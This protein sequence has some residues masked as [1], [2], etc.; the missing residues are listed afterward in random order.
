[1]HF[2]PHGDRSKV[3]VEP[4]LTTQWFVDSKKIVKEAIDVVREE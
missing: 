2:V 1:M 4:F 3:V